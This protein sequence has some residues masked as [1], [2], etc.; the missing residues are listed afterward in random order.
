MKRASDEDILEKVKPRMKAEAE[1]AGVALEQAKAYQIITQEDLDVANLILGDVK[2]KLKT[3]E[4]DEKDTTQSASTFIARVRAAFRPA[5]LAWGQIEMVLK[6]E[7]LNARLREE[8][9][10]KKALA[11]AREAQVAGDKQRH[12]AALERVHTTTDLSGTSIRTFW[13][14]EVED[15][16]KLPRSYL[17]PN[18]TKLKEHCAHSTAREPEPIPGV[19]FIPTGTVSARATKDIE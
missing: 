16:T 13:T 11:E 2:A 14:F 17:T 1:E 5:K 19:K 8:E 15:E 18:L 4:K 9:N 3:L 7:I 6:K 12:A 10:N